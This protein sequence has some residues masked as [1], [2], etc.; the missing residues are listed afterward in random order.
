[1]RKV[2]IL[3]IILAAVML[4]SSVSVLAFAEGPA[5]VSDFE[6]LAAAVEAGG[7]IEVNGY[8]S[9]ERTLTV[10][11]DITIYFTGENPHL[12]MDNSFIL[13][14]TGSQA[15]NMFV[16]EGAT[17][18]L[19]FSKGYGVLGF[20]G[21][22]S[23]IKL[24]GTAD[25]ETAF[26]TV[27]N[28]SLVTRSIWL[29]DNDGFTYSKSFIDIEN[30]NG[31]KVAVELDG[32][33]VSVEKENA[34]GDVFSGDSADIKIVSGYFGTTSVIEH[35]AENS[36]A[37][38]YESGSC[39]VLKIDAEPLDEVKSYLDNGTLI[40]KRPRPQEEMEM[41]LLYEELYYGTYNTLENYTLEL[42]TDLF[43]ANN[44]FVYVKVCEK[45]TGNVVQGLK[46][47]VAYEYE[48]ALVSQV[49]EIIDALPKG[50]DGAPYCYS[51]TDLEMLNFWITSSEYNYFENINNFINYSD[52]FKRN[53]GY[54][55]FAANIGYGA[56]ERLYTFCGG[57]TQFYYNGVSYGY[58]DLEVKGEHIFY[59]PDN[60]PDTPEALLEA[61]QKRVDAYINAG[62]IEPTYLGTALE[63]LL[64]DTY[65]GTRYEWEQVDPDM[66]F[67]EWK[68]S[69]FCPAIDVESDLEIEGVTDTTPLFSIT[70][71]GIE[72]QFLIKRDSSKMVNLQYKN[73]DVQSDVAVELSDAVIPLDTLIS[74]EKLTSGAEYERIQQTL[75]P[76]ESVTFDINLH[77]NS[78]GEKITRLDS[79]E[80]WVYM[81]IPEDFK[82]KDLE[83]RYV[84]ENGVVEEFVETIENGY[85]KFPTNH[86]SAYTLVVNEKTTGGAG[87]S[88]SIPAD[89]PNDSFTE[90]ESSKT[91]DTTRV[92][93]WAVMSAVSVVL[94]AATVFAKK[95]LEA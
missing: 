21:K 95:K 39:E 63:V 75:K 28:G 32:A 46:L 88:S 50:E 58:T 36:V 60:T 9:F 40:F 57:T 10:T 22:G 1:M 90:T 89:K 13:M 59:V 12:Q 73:V 24:V 70:I 82:D 61:F 33:S 51:V 14:Q 2:K 83:I 27:K 69:A 55:N 86:F 5:E 35:I 56:D 45:N 53:L 44:D 18:T 11:K 6:S 19:D 92:E 78:L 62:N 84:H 68:Q 49:K 72:H 93:L 94:L 77:S 52:E 74:V 8:I 30:P 16:V 81:P 17:L 25:K 4:I 91:A 38:E 65:E 80:F 43:D 37:I 87:G 42:V 67:D 64:K 26:K 31:D 79:G 66:T 76:K 85:I 15:E 20:N 71:N 34:Q 29:P 54:K 47:S 3:S 48:E 41:W 7:D 23:A